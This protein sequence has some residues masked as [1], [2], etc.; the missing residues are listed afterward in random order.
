MEFWDRAAAFV[1]QQAKTAS[2][3]SVQGYLEADGIAPVHNE[4]SSQ[5]SPF[6]FADGNDYLRH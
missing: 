1:Q 5:A 2:L 6:S 4:L 3:H